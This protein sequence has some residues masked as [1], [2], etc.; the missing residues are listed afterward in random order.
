V[1]A[2]RERL[3]N[4]TPEERAEYE[5]RISELR[6]IG[7]PMEQALSEASGELWFRFILGNRPLL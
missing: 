6:D 2:F 4:M 5:K 3:K 7:T 1:N